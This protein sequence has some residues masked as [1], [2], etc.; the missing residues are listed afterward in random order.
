MRLDQIKNIPQETTTSTDTVTEARLNLKKLGE[1]VDSRMEAI[2]RFSAGD[3]I[4]AFHEQDDDPIEIQSLDELENFTPDQLLA[5]PAGAVSDVTMP[6]KTA[7]PVGMRFIRDNVTGIDTLSRDRDGNL[8]FRRGYFYKMGGDA[9]KFAASISNQLQNLNIPHQILDKGEVWKP[10]RGGSKTHNQSHWWVKVQINPGSEQSDI[11]VSETSDIS[12]LMHAARHYNNSFIVTA[13]TAEGST[14]RYRVRAQ[15]ERTAREQFSK[16]HNQAEILS[17]KAE[18]LSEARG[19][20]GLEIGDDVI[21][22]GPVQFQGSTGVIEQFGRDNRFV[23][24]NLYNQGRRSF[25]SS[26]VSFNEYADSDAEEARMYDSDPEFRKQGV[27]SELKEGRRLK[28]VVRGDNPDVYAKVY[29]DTDWEEF[30]VR[31]FV[32]GKYAGEHSDY[33]AADLDDAMSTAQDMVR[34]AGSG[35][36]EGSLNESK[37]IEFIRSLISEFN[38]Q[39]SGS[40]YYP[41]DYKNPGMRM[42]T[43]GDGSRYKEPGYIFIDRDLKPGDEL[44]WRKA[45]AVEKFWKFLESKGARKIGDVSGE[46]GSDPHSPAIVLNK[47]IFVFNGNVV[48]W[49]STSRLKN[50]SVWRQKQP[51]VTE[52]ISTA[53]QQSFDNSDENWKAGYRDYMNDKNWKFPTARL[54]SREGKKYR[55]G[56]D[57]AERAVRRMREYGVTEGGMPS[58]VVKIKQKFAQ[59]TPKDFAQYTKD[60]SDSDLLSMAWKHGYGKGST[61]YVD[62]RNKGQQGVTPNEFIGTLDSKGRFTKGTV[63]KMFGK[64]S[65]DAEGVT[66]GSDKW[67]KILRLMNIYVDQGYSAEQAASKLGD[68]FYQEMGWEEPI[69]AEMN[70]L[71]KFKQSKQGMAEAAVGQSIDYASW[72]QKSPED[73]ARLLKDYPKL[74]ITDKPSEPRATPTRSKKLTLGDVWRKVETVVSQV[75]PDGDPIDWLSPWLNKH[76]INDFKVGEVLDRAARKNGYKDLYDYY[77]SMG[78][79]YPNKQGVAEGLEDMSTQQAITDTVERLFRKNQIS[80]YDSLEA[81]RQGVKHHF[82]KPGATAE[83]AIDGILNILTKR[84]R[85]SGNYV[86]LNRFREALRQGV[87]HQLKKS[88]VAEGYWEDAVKKAEAERQARRGKPFELNPASHDEHG[89]YKGDR[90]LAG[91]PVPREK[92]GGDHKVLKK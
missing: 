14:R 51:S 87:A 73:Q 88:G 26:D 6:S 57:E 24:V 27:E 48:A 61:Y 90:D 41:M 76:G 2:R 72:S 34:R 77:H 49:G 91:N 31:L 60:R 36:T 82:S 74:K 28:T 23:V 43:R 46:F 63:K 22:T 50:S 9:E 59:M 69:Q 54:N 30:Q 29:R 75:Y 15:S 21:I 19:A 62:K 17:V 42:W 89:V 78:E 81:V 71:A 13:R 55:A 92:Q 20:E 83:S 47:L 56:W 12:G 64:L 66:E 3:R 37:T 18:E 25:H 79:L 33:H 7:K 58:A 70:I 35:V 65:P 39:M 86:D 85:K 38:T 80:D 40:P 4:F 52:G 53:A 67:D 5:V 11:S 10:F 68:R 32:N 16:H 44:K 1:P 45:K 8:V 84:M